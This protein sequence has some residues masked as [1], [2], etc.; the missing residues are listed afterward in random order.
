M[1][2][3]TFVQLSADA[4]RYRDGIRFRNG[5]EV[6]LQEITEGVRFE[7]LSLVS[8]Q[9]GIEAQPQRVSDPDHAPE[10]PGDFFLFGTDTPG[11]FSETTD[12]TRKLESS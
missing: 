3:V 9:Q 8:S 5:K 12:M 10:R 1:E 2:D 6:S 4:Y 7:V 11:G